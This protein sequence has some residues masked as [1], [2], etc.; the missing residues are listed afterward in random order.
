M[1]YRRM[2]LGLPRRV[3]KSVRDKE[4]EMLVHRSVKT[5]MDTD[6]TYKPKVN[7]HDYKY[8]LVPY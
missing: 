5:K 4:D 3:P 7:F 1:A 6:P 2:N 8:K